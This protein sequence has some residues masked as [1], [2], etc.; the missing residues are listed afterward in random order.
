MPQ[1][2][3]LPPLPHPNPY[4]PRNPLYYALDL[5]LSRISMTEFDNTES[6]ALH[7]VRYLSVLC[8]TR[9]DT[10]S[11]DNSGDICNVLFHLSHLL[12]VRL[13][14]H[15]YDAL[16]QVVRPRHN[17]D[18]AVRNIALRDLAVLHIAL[19]DAIPAIKQGIMKPLIVSI[20]NLPINLPRK[21]PSCPHLSE[22]R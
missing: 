9:L 19:E 22:H 7:A 13:S 21:T 16:N 5:D 12:T 15:L 17:P 11:L 20:M 3:I 4:G 14:D 2:I 18:D 1:E 6:S 8:P 10:S